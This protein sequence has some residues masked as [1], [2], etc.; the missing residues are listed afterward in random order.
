MARK[1]YGQRATC[2]D[3]EPGSAV[4]AMGVAVFHVAKGVQERKFISIH[5][6]MQSS[7]PFRSTL[8]K[9]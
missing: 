8:V 5:R 4:E 1:D 2:R 3:Y 6:L 7:L 9:H